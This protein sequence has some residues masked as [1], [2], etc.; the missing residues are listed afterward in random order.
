MRLGLNN[1][2]Q[3]LIVM[4]FA[5]ALIGCGKKKEAPAN[6]D[7]GDNTPTVKVATD[8]LGASISGNLKAVHAH[9]A[10]GA[11]LDQRTQ[12]GQ[13]STP[14]IL[15]IIFGHDVV[16]T[17]LID[18]G[19]DV[20]LQQADG[21]TALIV[22][23][24]MGHSAIVKALLNYGADP[25]IKNKT[26]QTA[27]GVLSVTWE[28]AKGMYDLIGSAWA[29]HGL[30]IDYERIKKARPICAQILEAHVEPIDTRTAAHPPITDIF[31]AVLYEDLVATK[32]FI[33]EGVDV[34]ASEPEKGDTPL[35]KA[36][37]VC[38]IEIVK[39]L[40]TSGANVNAKNK[41]GETP[42]RVAAASWKGMPLFYGLVSGF[43]QKKFDLDRIKQDRGKVTEILR[44]AGAK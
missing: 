6:S 36:T 37:L 33:A 14:L 24:S 29:Q 5:T 43:T 19:A 39:A 42:L 1:M 9:I 3:F 13:N 38:N 34:N 41:K 44:A 18:A 10:T 2:K 16:A 30:K 11:D 25:N 23:A 17:V 7:A 28:D 22:A 21:S 12:D 8:L 15:A 32:K 26:G 31:G 20:N 40:I 35:H 27:L 4:L